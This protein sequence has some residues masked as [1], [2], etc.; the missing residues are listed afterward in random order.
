MN[1]PHFFQWAL[2]A[3]S[4]LTSQ[5]NQLLKPAP[6]SARK[7]TSWLWHSEEDTASVP[8]QKLHNWSNS[9]FMNAILQVLSQQALVDS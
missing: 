5:T 4:G 9:C 3:N 7:E 1:P 2:L 8:V 6:S